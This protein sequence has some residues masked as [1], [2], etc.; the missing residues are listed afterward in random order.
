MNYKTIDEVREA[1]K[2]NELKI[3]TLN[4]LNNE[5]RK[6]AG[7]FGKYKVGQKVKFKHN[8]FISVGVI[9]DVIYGSH[10]NDVWYT[11]ISEELDRKE[12]EHAYEKESSI[13]E[14]VG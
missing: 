2:E 11:I 9:E 13:I 3:N 8:G 12:R 7:K 10:T 6:Y 4:R 5:F 1:I 14:L